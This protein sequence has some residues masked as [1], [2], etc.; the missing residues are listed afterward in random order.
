MSGAQRQPDRPSALITWRDALQTIPV[1]NEAADV[2]DRGDGAV[3]ITVQRTRPRWLVPPLSWVIRP[4]LTKTYKLD[5]IGGEVWRLCDGERT[6]EAMAD[7][8]AQRHH[9][10]FHEARVAL[11]SYLKL[12]VERG[13]LVLARPKREGRDVTRGA[14]GEGE[15]S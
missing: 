15:S 7:A 6:V 2:D 9:L 4:R 13:A 1:R 12:L 11:M 5:G 8:F 10:T 14:N 3:A